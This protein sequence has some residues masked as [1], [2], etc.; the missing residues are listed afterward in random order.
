MEKKLGLVV[1]S[2]CY[3]NH[4][5]KQTAVAIT[6]DASEEEWM[7]EEV[8][9]GEQT[10][11]RL[12]LEAVGKVLLVLH[13]NKKHG[14]VHLKLISGDPNCVKMAHKIEVMYIKL[15][16]RKKEVSADVI[17]KV[18]HAQAQFR[19]LP[20]DD[21]YANILTLLW[22]SKH[23]Y[24]HF[25]FETHQADTSKEYKMAKLMADPLIMK[26]RIPLKNNI[27]TNS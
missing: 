25:V 9:C 1:R 8:L 18:I 15:L 17:D 6:V 14:V 16:K 23:R 24:G 27:R 2:A 26:K 13:Q 5:T 19:K 21:L 11:A 3:T 22:N 10:Y 12:W 7:L 20:N 4:K